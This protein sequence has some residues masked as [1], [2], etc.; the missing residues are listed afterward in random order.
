MLNN[1]KTTS[2][3]T[4]MFSNK[5]YNLNFIEGIIVLHLKK[6]KIVLFLYTFHKKLTFFYNNLWSYRKIKIFKNK[7]I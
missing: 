5:S 7:N 2:Q 1:S 4:L 3:Y 6:K